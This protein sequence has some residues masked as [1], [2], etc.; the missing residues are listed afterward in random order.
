MNRIF[1]RITVLLTSM[2]ILVG[3]S[4]SDSSSNK[5]EIIENAATKN[6]E[7]NSARFETSLSREHMGDQYTE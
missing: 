4:L 1:G 5:I 7:L 6:T 2:L 3:C